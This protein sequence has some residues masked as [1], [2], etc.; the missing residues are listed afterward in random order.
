MTQPPEPPPYSPPPQPAYSPS[1]QPAYG[2]APQPGYGQ[3]APPP[4]AYPAPPQK[5]STSGPAI[6]ALIFG[7]IGWFPLGVIFGIIGLVQTKGGKRSGRGMA[8]AGLVLSGLW[9]LGIIALVIILAILG[10]GS[11]SATDIKVG[12]CIE[13]NPANGST[14][15]QLPR[16]ACDKPHEGEVFALL[17]V[18]GDTFPGESTIMREY[19]GKCLDALQSYSP[20]AAEDPDIR[21]F[22]LYPTQGSWDRGDRQVACIAITT[23]KRSTSIKQ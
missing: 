15:S 18:P 3:Y 12:D 20:T 16:V 10:S 8:I 4:A 1:P 22:V 14:V 19:Q 13:Q 2:A 21:N 17:P 7:I 23:E 11:V 6:A 5:P 9:L